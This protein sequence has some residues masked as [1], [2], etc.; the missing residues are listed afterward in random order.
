MYPSS[1][2]HDDS[3]AVDWLSQSTE[4]NPILHSRDATFRMT[5]SEHEIAIPKSSAIMW[6]LRQHVSK[7]CTTKN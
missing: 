6:C 5:H 4:M 7:T 3:S 2:V 1:N